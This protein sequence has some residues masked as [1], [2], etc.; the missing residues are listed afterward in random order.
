MKIMNAVVCALLAL[1]G[2]SQAEFNITHKNLHFFSPHP[3]DILLTFGGLIHNLSEKGA[4]PQHRSVTEVFFGLSNYTTNHLDVLT[5][6]RVSDVSAQRFTEDF[7]S[8]ISMFGSWKNFRYQ[9]NGYYDA[10]LRLY[11]GSTTAGG[12]PAGTFLNFRA[13]EQEAYENIV[14]QV[15][16]TLK[17]ENC[18]AFILLA[19]GSHIDHFIV[20]EAVMKAAAE[21]GSEA[22][23]EIFF[24][25][26]QPYTGANPSNANDEIDS[27]KARLPAGSITK[28]SY[29]IDKKKK[30]DT[31]KEYYLSQYDVAYIPPLESSD[32][33]VLYRWDPSTYGAL[34]SHQNCSNSYCKIATK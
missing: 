26:D 11:R 6:K 17:K 28:Y 10:P 13:A 29:W 1:P 8:H 25:E 14:A 24:G 3:D 22:K 18:A 33:E 12:G 16:P 34:Q 32:F 30:I 19:N 5:N 21:L 27:I 20:R 7:L 15:K 2:M 31:F 23:C 4:L 9:S